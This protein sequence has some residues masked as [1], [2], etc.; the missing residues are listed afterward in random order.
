MSYEIDVD[1]IEKG[2]TAPGESLEN[3]HQRPRVL[4]LQPVPLSELPTP[5][6][7]TSRYR[8]S[9]DAMA[10]AGTPLTLSWHDL[11]Y[12]VVGLD[13]KKKKIL[14]GLTGAVKPGEIL[15]I[16]GPS[17]CGKTTFL[18]VLSGRHL[19]GDITGDILLNGQPR[20]KQ[21][22][23]QSAYVEQDDHMF[24]NLTVREMI[25]FSALLRLPDTYT[26]EEKLQRGEEVLRELGLIG[27]ANT[28]IGNAARR[29]VSGGERKR[30]SIGVELITNPRLLFLD[31]P[32]SGLDSNTAF[33]IVET[34]Q[35]L[36]RSGRAV[37]CTIHQPQAK[38]FALF[39]KLV[40]L[41]RGRVCYYGPVRDVD[42]YFA[43][44]QMPC[45]SHSN[46]ADHILDVTIVDLRS[47][48][49]EASTMARM[50]VFASSYNQ[51][52]YA[53]EAQR[54]SSEIMQKRLQGS[55]DSLD[56]E[57]QWN[58]TWMQETLILL[59]RAWLNVSRDPRMVKATCGQ[60]LILGLI[61][62]F[63]FFQLGH[64]QTGVRDRYS[65]LFFILLNQSFSI[66]QSGAVLFHQEKAVITRERN[67]G[68]YRVSSYFLSK[69]IA[70]LPIIMALPSIHAIIVYW[71]T[72]LNPTAGA[73][74]TFLFVFNVTIVT[75]Q[76]YGL[77]ISAVT[78]SFEVASVI[79]PVCTIILML[80]GGFYLNSRSIWI[81]FVWIEALSFL[82]Y[83]FTAVAVNEFRGT[84][85]TCSDPTNCLGTGERVLETLNFTHGNVWEE[86]GKL[87]ALCVGLRVIAYFCLLLLRRERLKLS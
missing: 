46:V 36:A 27:C 12:D 22:R 42:D 59:R 50:E 80:F 81:G 43:D 87:F 60:A 33:N 47:E 38:T 37:I 14:F 8:A 79:V 76:S 5:Q 54:E 83:S 25:R 10:P 49:A 51:S 69:T 78:P 66:V 15:S 3:R 68:A 85:W 16:M 73:F 63:L 7:G 74:F 4:T 86:I 57:S 34:L 56:E 2:N 72:G 67:A 6:D 82:K 39:D 53:I 70:E 71:L 24:P 55:S 64:D 84:T 52:K 31:E 58:L 77:V 13:K 61:V 44:L 75:A 32:T 19:N 21:F 48:A 20:T 9:L 1:Q 26:H 62:G 17:G 35:L 23:R 18:N 40:L 29:G 11:Q 30:A 28:L 45:P 41:S 65:V